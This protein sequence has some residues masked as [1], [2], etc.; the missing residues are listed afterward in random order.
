[1]IKIV[2]GKNYFFRDQAYIKKRK[3]PEKGTDFYENK[4]NPDRPTWQVNSFLSPALYEV[5]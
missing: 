3:G 5:R 1:M 4:K 2:A